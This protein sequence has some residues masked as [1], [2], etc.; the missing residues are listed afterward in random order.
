QHRDQL[1][2]PALQPPEGVPPLPQ[3]GKPG[4]ARTEPHPPLP[5]AGGGGGGG[6]GG[7][8]AAPLTPTPLPRGERGASGGPTPEHPV[9][10]LILILLLT[11]AVLMAF[12]VGFTVWFQGYIYTEP[13]TGILWRGPAAGTAVM[14]ALVL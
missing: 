5:P 2:R 1:P 9:L 8:L 4:D 12:L 13:T 3:A 6:G 10:T 7:L 14:A 11:W